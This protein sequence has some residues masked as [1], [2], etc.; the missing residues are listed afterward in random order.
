MSADTVGRLIKAGEFPAGFMVGGKA[1]FWDWRAV[2]YCRLR[3]ELGPRLIK[4]PKNSR[5]GTR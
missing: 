2:A 5:E 4:P 3:L 1:K